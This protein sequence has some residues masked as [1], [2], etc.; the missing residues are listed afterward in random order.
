MCL[1]GWG[2]GKSWV[3]EDNLSFKYGFQDVAEVKGRGE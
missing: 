1:S 3:T 2:A